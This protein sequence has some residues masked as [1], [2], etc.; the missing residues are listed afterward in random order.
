MLARR[1]KSIWGLGKSV[2]FC[3]PNTNQPK[4]IT[5]AHSEGHSSTERTILWIIL[6]ATIA[7]SLYFTIQSHKHEFN[8]T[9]MSGDLGDLRKKEMPAP[10]PASVHATDTLHTDTLHHVPAAAHTPAKVV[11]EVIETKPQGH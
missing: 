3:A 11:E 10:A 9:K 5:M 4:K 1:L 7:V 2:L 8:R 6:P